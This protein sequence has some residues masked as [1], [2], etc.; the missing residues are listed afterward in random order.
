MESVAATAAAAAV[1]VLAAA[2]KAVSVPAEQDDDEDQDPDTVVAVVT[3]HDVPFLPAKKL[4]VP[5]AAGGT[6]E[7]SIAGTAP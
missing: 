2:A 3:K 4:L 1:V 7:D 5:L 6:A